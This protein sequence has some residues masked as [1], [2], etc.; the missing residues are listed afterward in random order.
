M[1]NLL[2]ENV[3]VLDGLESIKLYSNFDEVVKYLKDNQ[4][5][6]IY[7]FWSNKG[8]TPE[9]P[10]KIIRI[11]NS[12]NLFFAKDKLW[13]I[14]LENDY[15]GSLDNGIKLGMKL[16]EALKIDKSLVY[17]DWDEVYTS[18]DFYDIEDNLDDNTIMS[19]SVFIKEMSDDEVFY[20][21][22]W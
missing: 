11:Q 12:I 19:I 13:K 4:I 2:I 17:D 9:V 7:E 15:Q 20:K 10:W 5:K 3:K 16:D 14:Y 21:Y 18:K 6:Y 8:C 22:E 1:K